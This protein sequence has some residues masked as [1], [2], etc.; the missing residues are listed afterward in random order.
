MSDVYAISM[1]GLRAYQ[2][3]LSV[4][5][6]N[7]ANAQTP[8][9]TKRTVSLKEHGATAG[10]FSGSGVFVAGV[11]RPADAY[12]A[13]DVR[14]SSADLARTET[15]VSWLEQIE[16]ALSADPV[17]TRLTSFFNAANTLAADP[18]A[19]TP[20][21]QMLEAAGSVANAFTQSGAALTRLSAQLDTSADQSV[22]TLNGLAQTLARINDGLTRSPANIS[23]QALLADQR[24]QV[25]DQMSALTDTTVTLDDAGRAT[26]RLGGDSGPILTAPDGGSGNLK[27]TRNSDGSF[28]FE[29]TRG[30]DHSSVVPTGGTLAGITD[31]AQ[32]I[33]DARTAL[34]GLATDF[35]TAANDFQA[36]GRDLDGNP[37]PAMFA[38]DPADPT[39][40][41]VTLTDP[42]KIAAASPGGGTRDNANLL[43]LAAT[44]S[45]G[46][47]EGRATVM[48]GQNATALSS[49]RSIASAQN[50]IR[51]GAVARFDATAGVDLDNEAVELMR[52]QQ[53][54]QGCARAIQVGREM[55]Q[56]LIEST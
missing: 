37:G 9:Y 14:R 43:A 42:R 24:D 7:I 25:L 48:I 20:R 13:A 52:Y 28:A 45:S 39:K 50:S 32:R 2:G 35:V 12:R 16:T 44:R 23:A 56:S 55:F 47:F 4:V 49:A 34:K 29:L 21:T 6:E 30:L 41:T 51:D 5:S 10:G 22:V 1:S 19:T 15:G 38:Q 33:G 54:Y 17:G 11:N 8:G 3:A 46:N 26:V 40:V 36:N 53:A 27:Y 31:S 18:T